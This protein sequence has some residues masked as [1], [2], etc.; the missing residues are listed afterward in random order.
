MMPR[1]VQI[2][3]LSTQLSP[4]AVQTSCLWGAENSDPQ[5]KNGAVNWLSSVN[6]K[7]LSL[8]R[9]S[10]M[11]FC[12]GV[13]L[14]CLLRSHT[15]KQTTGCSFVVIMVKVEKKQYGK[16]SPY[17]CVKVTVKLKL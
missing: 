14:H 3:E 15:L 11:L 13:S 4:S 6:L 1:N 10:R 16:L 12:C 7:Q 2:L 5:K 9:L 8:L 17:L